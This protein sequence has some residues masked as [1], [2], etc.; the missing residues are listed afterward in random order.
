MTI[1][2]GK[3]TSNKIINELKLEVDNLNKEGIFPKLA[4]IFIGDDISSKI[5]IKNKNRIC[6]EIGI[7]YEE[8]VMDS[9][10]TME[11]LM[12]LINELN[13]REDISGILLQSPIPKHL[14]ISK[15]FNEIAPNKDVDGFNPINIGK[16]SIGEDCFVPCTAKGI[17]R[18]LDE[19]KIDIEGKNVVVIGRSI[20]VGKPLVQ[21]LLKR[22][23]T[24]TVC[25]TKTRNLSEHT[26]N[27]DIVISAAGHQNL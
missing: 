11:N 20:I 1:I 19:Y 26:K 2:D 5:Y 7:E 21:C 14:D 4:V 17:V 13:C 27:A 9:N 15:A 22:N 18:L 16:L 12:N 24:V 3:K 8:F 23:A 25:H 6:N 10:T